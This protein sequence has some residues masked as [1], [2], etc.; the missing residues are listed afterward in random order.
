LLLLSF[1]SCS[2]M[3]LATPLLSTCCP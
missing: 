1:A 2:S 3:F